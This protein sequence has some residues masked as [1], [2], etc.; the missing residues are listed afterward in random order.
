VP[1]AALVEPAYLASRSALIEAH[2]SM[3]HA[4]AGEPRGVATAFGDDA[5]AEAVGTSHLAIVDARGDVVSMTTSIEGDFGTRIMAG[6]FFLNN[7]LTD[8]SFSA[9]E[10]GRPVANAV[11]GGK[12]PRSSMAPM[13]VFDART[14]RLEMALGSPGGSLIIDY[15][16]KV[17]VAALDWNLDLQAAIDLPHFGSR[18][19]PTEIER[20]T[21]L[22]SLS[23]ALAAMGHEVRAI[24]M[25]SGVHA[26]RRIPGGWQGAADP[27]R[28]GVALGR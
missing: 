2:R 11:A 6:G 22:E 15:V 3:R 14:G 12:R 10:D 7:T 8:F 25:T 27:R 5:T 26:I 1:V 21:S 18:N 28:E 4:R 13:M 16:A 19:G 24:D 17:L 9:L 23:P 20:R